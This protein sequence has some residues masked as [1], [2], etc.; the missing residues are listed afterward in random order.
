MI[1]EPDMTCMA[2]WDHIECSCL[3]GG[4]VLGLVLAEFIS[5]KLQPFPYPSPDS[6]KAT[7]RPAAF[8]EVR[9]I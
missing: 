5:E 9:C 3:Y 6:Q 7:V 8:Y 4:I 1:H 2:A